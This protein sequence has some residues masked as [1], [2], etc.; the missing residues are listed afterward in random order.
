MKA[1]IIGGGA[2]AE[3]HCQA[4]TKLGVEVYAICDL[5]IKAAQTLAEQYRAKA[6]GDVSL[7]LAEQVDF[8][9]VCTPSGTHPALAI[10]A[11]EAG[12]HVVV[13]KP[14]AL[15][16]E[17]CKSVIETEKKTGKICAP[18]S[19]L[20]FSETYKSV[21]H[22]IE[23]GELGTL[24]TGSLSMHYYRAPEYYAGSWKGTKA[25]DG[26]EL[27]N[28][29]I[30]GLDV[31]CGLLGKPTQVSGSV[32]TR[33]HQ[34][35]TEDTA[36]ASMIYPGG[37]MGTLESSTA[38]F[39]STPRRMEICGTKGSITMIE[40]TIS[41][42][43]GV[44]LELSPQKKFITNDPKLESSEEHE[45]IYKNILAAFLGKEKLQYTTKDAA[46]TVHLICA[47]Y[48]SSETKQVI[49]LKEEL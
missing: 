43:E 32:V 46:N 21:K 29:G 20:R 17:D 16:V 27:F 42:A 12:K 19:Q 3:Q 41:V 37:M 35:E 40:D 13:E 2:I 38:V 11:M 9:S 22:I 5:N 30:H 48:E 31:M 14:L 7:A 45:R 25:L 36:V 1:L 39:Y 47:I 44:S 28:Q 15:C 24:V 34:I 10:Q 26:G 23:A 33:L 8:V 6:F 49:T 18:I 4:L